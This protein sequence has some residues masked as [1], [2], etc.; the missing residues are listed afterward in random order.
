MANAI[1]TS[2]HFNFFEFTYKKIKVTQLLIKNLYMI[3]D[4][5]RNDKTG[6]IHQNCIKL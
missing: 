1:T 5:E 3:I 6:E 2:L 4:F